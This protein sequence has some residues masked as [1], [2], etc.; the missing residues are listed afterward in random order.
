MD[1][2]LVVAILL[3]FLPLV[4]LRAGLPVVIDYCL[5]NGLNIGPYF[6][7]VVLINILI[8]LFVFI[9]MDFF[10]IHFLKISLYRK[11]MERYLEKVK[12][13]GRYLEKKKGFLLHL[14]LCLFVAIPLP[15]TGAWTGAVLAWLLGFK[16]K[17]SFIAISAGVLIAGFLVLGIS[18]G[19]LNFF[20]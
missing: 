10:H 13:R 3:S 20:Y 9:F 7:L 19:I 2:Q 16:R 15:G 4:E 1:T 8:T 18:L 11:F 14:L 12:K 17:E 5:K 6:M